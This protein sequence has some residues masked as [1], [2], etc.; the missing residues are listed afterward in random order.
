MWE[1]IVTKFVTDL[2]IP[3]TVLA[4]TTLGVPLTLRWMRKAGIDL[5]N[6]EEQKITTTIENLV[7]TAENTIKGSGKGKVRFEFVA[8]EVAKEL[9]NSAIDLA[10]YNLE[11]RIEAMHNKLFGGGDRGA[12]TT[13]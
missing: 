4:I 6:A 1:E 7:R 13:N 12:D 10:K 5:S 8:R 9:S 2:L 3:I 11:A